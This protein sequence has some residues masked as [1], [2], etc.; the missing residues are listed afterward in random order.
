MRWLGDLRSSL[1]Y[2][3]VGA[4]RDLAVHNCLSLASLVFINFAQLGSLCISSHALII[5][6]G[7]C[8]DVCIIAGNVPREIGPLVF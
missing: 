1:S 2:P 7:L 3:D 6:A 8:S 4:S 5:L